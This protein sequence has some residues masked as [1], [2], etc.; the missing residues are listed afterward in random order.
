MWIF[1]VRSIFYLGKNEQEEKK[2]STQ[3]IKVDSEPNLV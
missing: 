3:N 1:V 2:I